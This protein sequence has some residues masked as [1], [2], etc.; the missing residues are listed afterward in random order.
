MAL[1]LAPATE[2]VAGRVGSRAVRL[3]AGI[4]ACTALLAAGFG[5][6]RVST[7]RTA[8]APASAAA[9]NAGE[10]PAAVA[11]SLIV[12]DPGPTQ[13]VNDVG[14]GYARSEAGAVAAA[15]GYLEALG[16]KR[17]FDPGWRERAYRTVADPA[18]ADELIASVDESYRRVDTEL[19]LGD[20][21][22]YN[23]SV[24]AVTVPVGY[25]VDSYDQERA[26]VTVWAAGWLIQS[27]GPELPLRA[28]TATV[29]LVWLSDDWKLTG[30][31]GVQPLDPPG[32]AAPVT[33]QA[34]AEMRGFN[35]YDYQPQEQQ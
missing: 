17:A 16:D 24:L 20:G 22:A 35:A 19:G 7:T 12:T 34:L 18:V 29:E 27:S 9:G 14:T 8:P 25:R 21:A 11:E 13:Y 4:L 3:L 15:T 5:L 1:R 33:A 28:Q 26:T 2:R 30:V 32:V 31:T 6:G 10:A 23:G